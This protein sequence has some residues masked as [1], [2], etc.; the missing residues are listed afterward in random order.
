M[1]LPPTDDALTQKISIISGV[2]LSVIFLILLIIFVVLVVCKRRRKKSRQPSSQVTEDTT[3][4]TNASVFKPI[5][6]TDCSMV[7]TSPILRSKV[8]KESE[9]PVGNQGRTKRRPRLL[10]SIGQGLRKPSASHV[11]LEEGRSYRSASLVSSSLS[12]FKGSELTK[13]QGKN[14]FF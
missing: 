9:T 14:Y 1:V 2:L 11:S 5:W 10:T 13:Q 12:F 4:E 3:P 8:M 7:L 6:S